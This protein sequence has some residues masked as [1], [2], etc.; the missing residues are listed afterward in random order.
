ML[1]EA[2]ESS[3]SFACGYPGWIEPTVS[4]R[5]HD[6]EVVGEDSIP[7]LPE[8][9][10]QGR[11]ARTGCAEK[12]GAA[13]TDLDGAAMEDE[14]VPLLEQ[15]AKSRAEQEQADVLRV[16]LHFGLYDDAPAVGHKIPRHA[17]D[18]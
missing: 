12:D 1:T 3:Q 6:A 13:A 15:R 17:L 7:P 10:R 4:T 14:I 16:R 11:L 2:S 5:S 8:R 9:Q 18:A